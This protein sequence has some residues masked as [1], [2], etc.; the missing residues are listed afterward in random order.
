MNFVGEPN[1]RFAVDGG[2]AGVA[3]RAQFD[4]SD[5]AQ[6]HNASARGIASKNNG[7]EF[8]RIRQTAGHIHLVGDGI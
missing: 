8:G 5:V 2:A 7:A 3:A 6:T 1:G 4:S